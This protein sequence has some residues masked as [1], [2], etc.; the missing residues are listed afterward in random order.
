MHVEVCSTYWDRKISLFS[1]DL[2]KVRGFMD[3]KKFE[4]MIT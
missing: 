1:V 2:V 3:F 4:H